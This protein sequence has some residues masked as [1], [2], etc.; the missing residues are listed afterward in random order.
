M[1]SNLVYGRGLYGKSIYAGKLS[2]GA[3]ENGR[4][5]TLEFYPGQFTVIAYAK[6]G[7]RTAI[8]GNG[9]EGNA[10]SKLK[11]DINETGCGRCELT[12][13][14]LPDNSSLDY[15]QRIDI[16]LFGD[17][18]P[19]YSGY[20]LTRPIE[21]TTEDTFTFRGY[22]YYNKLEYILIF[23]TYENVDVGE[24]ARDIAIQAER[25]QGL[26]YNATKIA[27][28]GYRPTKI[29]FDGVTAAEALETLTDFAIDYVFGVDEYRSIYFKRR[30]TKINEQARLTVGQHITDYTPTWD[31]SKIVNW[32]RIKSGTID[33]DGEQWICVVQDT[34]SQEKY[35]LRQEIWDLP[36][37]YEVE[38]AKRWGQNQ[39]AQY[40]EPQKSAKIKNVR[41]EYP[42]PDGTFNVRHM[43]TDGQAEIRRLDGKAETYPITKISY[44]VSGSSGIKADLELGKPV[45]AID[46][47][48]ANIER[49]AKDLEQSQASAI[50]QLKGGG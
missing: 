5:Q 29:V 50:K 7:T 14:K 47:Y 23:K 25:A 49:K 12:F 35:G 13:H 42:Y 37:A 39:I 40:K 19:W 34:I 17:L 24:I 3:G 4:G 31:A 16:H 30:N 32:A 15:M 45:F 44:N 33:E 1:S 38:D 8:F 21:G 43:N 28:V 10:L 18:Q 11:F 20:I 22:G 26:V 6:D 48:L 46:K 36:Q 2:G 27:D 41:L 9:S